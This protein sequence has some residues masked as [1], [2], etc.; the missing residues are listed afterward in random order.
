MCACGGTCGRCRIRPTLSDLQRQV[1]GLRAGQRATAEWADGSSATG[2]LRAGGDRFWLAIALGA[3]AYACVRYRTG[4]PA[5]GLTAIT[6]D[7]PPMPEVG[8]IVQFTN[9]DV[10][11][12]FRYGDMRP[13]YHTEEW[14]RGFLN[15]YGYTD[16]K[17]IDAHDPAWKSVI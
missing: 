8:Q 6:V 10:G 7:T 17:V 12:C 13:P 3:D 4:L 16:I 5:A 9:G 11:E 1:N 2:V 15:D 14:W